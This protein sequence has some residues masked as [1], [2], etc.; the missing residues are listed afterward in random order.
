MHDLKVTTKM[1]TLANLS[2]AAVEEF[3]SHFRG[4]VLC[5]DDENYDNVRVIWNGM[6][7][8]KPALIA[9]CTGCCR[10]Y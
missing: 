5:A 2:G 9:R 6:H 7:D 8:K 3:K 4:E 1:A 10:C